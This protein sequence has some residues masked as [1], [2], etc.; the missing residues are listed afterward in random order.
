MLDGPNV[1]GREG[2][3]YEAGCRAQVPWQTRMNGTVAYNIPKV[4]VLVST[5]FQSL[6][7]AASRRSS[8]TYPRP[9]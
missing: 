9:P 3:E 1:R 6:P 4:D 5:V 7:G 8:R 2:N